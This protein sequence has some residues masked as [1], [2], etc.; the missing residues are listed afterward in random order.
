MEKNQKLP[1]LKINHIEDNKEA[2][3]LS[4]GEKRKKALETYGSMRYWPWVK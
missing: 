3:E 4:Y 1:P 2:K